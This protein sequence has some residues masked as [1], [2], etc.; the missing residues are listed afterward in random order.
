MSTRLAG[1]SLLREGRAYHIDGC[2]ECARGRTDHVYGGH[3]TA[4]EYGS[5]TQ[6]HGRCSCG[7][8]SPCLDSG[9]ARKRWHAEHKAEVR[10]LRDEK[11][12]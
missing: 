10:A 9:A 8:A 3:V 1:H 6:G 2:F 12:P 11:T 5:M 4:V 7:D